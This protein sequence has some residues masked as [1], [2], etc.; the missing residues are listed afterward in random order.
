MKTFY[1]AFG[2]GCALRGIALKMQFPDRRYAIA[3]GKTLSPWFCEAFEWDD[4]TAA[5]KAKKHSW[6]IVEA[7]E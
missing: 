7:A 2:C 5:E 4:A 6:T 3:Y 1:L